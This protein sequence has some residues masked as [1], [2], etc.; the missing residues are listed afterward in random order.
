MNGPNKINPFSRLGKISQYRN[1]TND[2]SLKSNQFLIGKNVDQEI[3][4]SFDP[5]HQSSVISIFNQIC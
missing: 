2:I 1:V 5:N 4:Q 3:N